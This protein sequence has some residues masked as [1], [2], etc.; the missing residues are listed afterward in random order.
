[1]D[2]PNKTK[3]FTLKREVLEA[4]A[5]GHSMNEVLFQLND[6]AWL[7]QYAEALRVELQTEKKLR[8]EEGNN[9]KKEQSNKPTNYS[10]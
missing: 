7:V 8:V 6:V 2:T 9:A 1:M 3:L 4:M 5:D 10:T